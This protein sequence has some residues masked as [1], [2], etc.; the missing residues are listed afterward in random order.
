MI[1]ATRYSLS[2]WLA[3]LRVRDDGAEAVEGGSRRPVIRQI[4]GVASRG[5]HDQRGW[6]GEAESGAGEASSRDRARLANRDYGQG[7]WGLRVT[8]GQ[9]PR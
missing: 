1:R 5:F 6:R 9:Q 8:N 4:G 2:D 3:G 7:R